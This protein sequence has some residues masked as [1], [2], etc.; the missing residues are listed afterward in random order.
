M[1]EG[2]KSIK[3]YSRE[4]KKEN[5][6]EKEKETKVFTM[7]LTKKEQDRMRA[8]AR[9]C[10]ISQTQL[11]KKLIGGAELKAI[12]PEYFYQTCEYLGDIRDEILTR[13]EDSEA[14][15]ALLFVLKDAISDFKSACDKFYNEGIFGFAYEKCQA[16]FLVEMEESRAMFGG[17]NEGEF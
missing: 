11:I 1:T 12:P 4:I 2:K 7:R 13:Y 17:A 8:L 9:A 16:D 15:K 14:D 10:G 5:Q 3:I 6:N